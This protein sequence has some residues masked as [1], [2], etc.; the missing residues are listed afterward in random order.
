MFCQ[1][2]I[3]I[4]ILKTTQYG[5]QNIFQFCRIDKKINDHKSKTTSTEILQL[6]PKMVNSATLNFL[7]FLRND[8][9]CDLLNEN[10]KH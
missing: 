7:T 4:L 3:S 1:K 2:N 10:Q 9:P 8:N 6:I 5:G